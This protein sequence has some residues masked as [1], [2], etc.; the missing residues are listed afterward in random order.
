MKNVMYIVF[1]FVLAFSACDG[2]VEVVEGEVWHLSD[3]K[4]T[5]ASSE[6]SLTESANG[7]TAAERSDNKTY[8]GTWV[9][10]EDDQ[11]KYSPGQDN[12]SW[13]ISAN[14][15]PKDD[16][17]WQEAGLLVGSQVDR[18]NIDQKFRRGIVAFDMKVNDH[19]FLNSAVEISVEILGQNDTNNTG[20][21]PG[22][23]FL[24][25]NV[26][27]AGNLPN[28]T[29]WHTVRLPMVYDDPWAS[30]GYTGLTQIFRFA[31]NIIGMNADGLELS[32]RNLRIIEV[33]E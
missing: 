29:D 25:W 6:L 14:Y 27:V 1:V 17:I 31:F 33:V 18:I 30:V 16:E 12:S 32:L 22:F 3:G 11:I 4:I 24:K 9:V 7:W 5:Q 13:T 21:N 8:S 20:D 23:A 26:R 15:Y 19:T 28:N 10:G 2:P